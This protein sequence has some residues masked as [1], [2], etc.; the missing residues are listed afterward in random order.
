MPAQIMP[1]VNEPFPMLMS[2]MDGAY[3]Q[4]GDLIGD[5]PPQAIANIVRTSR[6]EEKD[7]LLRDITEFEQR[8]H[9]CLDEAFRRWFRGGNPSYYFGMIRAIV[10]DPDNYKLYEEEYLRIHINSQ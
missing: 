8:F 3:D 1:T 9:D 10:A 7:Q 4:D 2:V 5:T 6:Q